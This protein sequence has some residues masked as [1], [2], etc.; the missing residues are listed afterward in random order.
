MCFSWILTKSS[1][2]KE[3]PS[4]RSTSSVLLTIFRLQQQEGEAQ[5]QPSV[6]EVVTAG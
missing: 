1:T 3:W 6:E 5:H 4:G 2:V